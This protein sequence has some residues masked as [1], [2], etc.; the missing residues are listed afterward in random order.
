M[1]PTDKEVEAGTDATLTCI[2]T[3]IGEQLNAVTWRKDGTDVTT[4]S[5]DNYDVSAGTWGS[6]SQTTTL[7]VKAAA[8]TVDST[9]TCS[10]TS[11]E[12]LEANKETTMSLNV[13]S[14][15]R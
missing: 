14:K 5:G 3:G 15:I 13:F 6:N 8:N 2:V 1:Q 9:Y 10:I 11:F 4:L 7:V 12:W